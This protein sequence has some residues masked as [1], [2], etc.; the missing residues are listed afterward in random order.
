MVIQDRRIINEAITAWGRTQT[1]FDAAAVAFCTEQNLQLYAEM[2]R[3]FV[4]NRLV[5]KPFDYNTFLVKIE[6][7]FLADDIAAIKLK[8]FLY[9]AEDASK[10]AN[11]FKLAAI[12]GD[13]FAIKACEHLAAGPD[14][15]FWAEL[16][17]AVKNG[18]K[19]TTPEVLKVARAIKLLQLYEYKSDTVMREAVDTV[20][21]DKE[22]YEIDMRLKERKFI[23][24]AD[25][26]IRIGFAVQSETEE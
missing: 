17:E 4:S 11:L 21:S 13:T 18:N 8:A 2:K 6:E 25:D 12:W 23:E 20:L 10:A 5:E 24:A 19:V 7:R 1:K 22:L 3:P 15:V 14:K 9:I 26:R 16:F